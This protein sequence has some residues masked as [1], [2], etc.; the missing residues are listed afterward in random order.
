MY[1]YASPLPTDQ[2]GNDLQNF[3]TAK[4]ANAVNAGSA[5]V[6]SVIT[7]NDNTTTIEVAAMSGAGGSG[8]LL[9]WVPTTDTAA[10]VTSSNFD[11]S[12]PP[13]YYRQFVVPIE[14]RGNNSIVGLN[15]QNGLYQRVAI[16]AHGA[17]A[18]SVYLA[19]Y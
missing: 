16:I 3:P 15:K 11:N 5:L 13:N 6:S 14:T 17:P 4:K 12:V 18:A 10:S 1:T 19:E 9:R 8:L 7:L 2:K